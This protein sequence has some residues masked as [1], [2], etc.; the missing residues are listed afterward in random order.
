M[1]L[2]AD[3]LLSQLREHCATIT[4]VPTTAADEANDY[5][6]PDR[7]SPVIEEKDK[8]KPGAIEPFRGIFTQQ[9][10]IP[11]EAI[12]SAVAVMRSGRL[13]RYNTLAGEESETSGLEQEFARYLG[14][15][16]CLACA[17]GGYAMQLA[18]RAI[19]LEQ[20]Q[21]VLTNAFTLS[22]VPGAIA[23]A[24]GRPILVDST[25]QLVL[26][27]D[28]LEN[29]I[30]QTGARVLLLSHMRGHIVDMDALMTLVDQYELILIEDCA[31]TMGASWNGKKTGSFGRLA[32]FST[33]TYKHINSGE[34]GLL[35]TND[36]DAFARAT[37]NSGSYMLYQRNGTVPPEEHF[38]EARYQVPN[39]SG[40]MDNLRAAILRPQLQTLDENCSRWNERYHALASV[41]SECPQLELPV[42]PDKEEFV[43]SSLQFLM[44]GMPRDRALQL[45]SEL[46]LLN[47]ELKWFGNR[48]P[49]GF[50]SH[51]SSWRYLA[52][53][54]L[55]ATNLILDELFDI[56]LP[57]TFSLEDCRE[58][59]RVIVSTV[60]QLENSTA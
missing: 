27:L 40:R 38:G 19:G 54:E 12:E 15:K 45:L 50:T 31:H 26:D 18:L 9:E 52:P 23:A 49:V 43:A 44:P 7:E 22:P 46:L 20:D 29:T 59:G 16:Y 21:G 8:S 2:Q 53:S 30:K 3:W 37:L 6:Y 4:T 56:R 33:Q 17:S 55:P 25:R 39:C 34:G 11:E 5:E 47:V 41:L 1:R 28:A 14:V 36:A 57:L 60:K 13:H 48:E 42:R 51:Y 35:T 24:G 32:C 10:P 58:L